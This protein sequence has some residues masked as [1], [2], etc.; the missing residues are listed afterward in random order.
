MLNHS[1][2]MASHKLSLE[3]PDTLNSCIIR[4]IDSSIY[5]EGVS[6][7]CPVLQVTAPGFSS[8]KTVDDVTPNFS[9]N[10]SACAIKIQS[11]NCGSVFNDIPDGVYIIK[12]S[13]SPNEYVYVEYNHLRITKALN[14]LK[15]L[16]CE[17]D[18]GACEPSQQQKKYL[19]ELREIQ[20]DLD[21]AKAK[22]EYCRSVNEGLTLYKYAMS[23]LDKIQCKMC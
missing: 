21:A 6:V 4:I 20:D 2:N 11:D 5:A 12:Y 19:Q 18:R 15:S 10:L 13:V 7:K 23:R 14:K 16:Y 3:V 22:V 1:L 9:L 8:P 17:L